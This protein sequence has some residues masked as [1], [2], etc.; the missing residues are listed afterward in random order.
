M[1]KKLLANTLLPASLTASGLCFAEGLAAASAQSV[2]ASGKHADYLAGYHQRIGA[3]PQCSVCHT[4]E[5]VSDT[6]SEIDSSCIKCHGSYE[7]MG[8]KDKAAGKTY[9]RMPDTF[10][11]THVLLVTAA[12]RQVL[13]TATTAIFLIWI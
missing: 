5:K 7:Q 4:T 9:L 11:L 6:Q 12:M 8:G 10:P 13:R 2:Y 3:T 1:L